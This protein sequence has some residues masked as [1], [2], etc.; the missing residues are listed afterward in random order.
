M[1]L[2]KKKKK[3]KMMPEGNHS[4]EVIAISATKI[5][6]LNFTITAKSR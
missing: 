1:Q 4:K 3:K 6:L 5:D 2:A